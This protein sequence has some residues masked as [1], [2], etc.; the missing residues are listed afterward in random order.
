MILTLS[1]AE[2]PPP[3]GSALSTRNRSSFLSTPLMLAASE[4]TVCPA[5]TVTTRMRSGFSAAFSDALSVLKL[6]PTK[7]ATLSRSASCQ[8]RRGQQPVDLAAG[9]DHRDVETPA[10]SLRARDRR[11]VAVDRLGADAGLFEPG[12][13]AALH[14]VGER[15]VLVDRHA[16]EA[17][18]DL[19]GPARGDGGGRIVD[20]EAGRHRERDAEARMQEG[21]AAHIAFFRRVAEQHAVDARRGRNR[22]RAFR[23][24]ARRTAG[25]GV[26]PARCAAA[27]WGGSPGS[28]GWRRPRRSRCAGRYRRPSIAGSAPPRT[29]R[30]R[31]C[32]RS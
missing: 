13:P 8:R 24:R 7:C 18:G 9:A 2:T 12:H 22:G 10:L 30:S 1:P 15:N 4:P 26:A 19:A 21:G 27:R 23:C 16:V 11:L 5:C 25:H 20:D 6:E 32:P 3:G 29:D 28:R 31:R 17:D 14:I